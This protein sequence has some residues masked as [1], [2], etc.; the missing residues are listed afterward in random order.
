MAN[1]QPVRVEQAALRGVGQRTGYAIMEANNDPAVKAIVI[2]GA[3]DAFTA[4]NDLKDFG[5]NPPKGADAPVFQFMDALARR[6]GC[7]LLLDVNNL[8]VNQCNH[9][10]DALAAIAAIAPG[11]VGEIHLAGHLVTPEALIDELP[12]MAWPVWAVLSTLTAQPLAHRAAV[13]LL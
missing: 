3:G 8:Y 10:E 11:S 6:T 13:L 7:R 9:G 4:G 1:D 2:T 5:E 12:V